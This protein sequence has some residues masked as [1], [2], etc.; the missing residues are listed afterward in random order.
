MLG[1]AQKAAAEDDVEISELTEDDPAVGK[2]SDG[3]EVR[4]RARSGELFHPIPYVLYDCLSVCL[5]IFC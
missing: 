5:F 3:G 4:S 1:C 2:A